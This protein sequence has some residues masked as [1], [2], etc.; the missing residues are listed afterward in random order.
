[1]RDRTAARLGLTGRVADEQSGWVGFVPGGPNDHLSPEERE[2]AEA[3][4]HARIEG[5]GRTLG[6]VVV[7]V[8]ENEAVPQVQGATDPAVAAELVR[9]AREVLASWR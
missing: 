9:R 8:Y 3:E 6:R 1:M 5:R 4:Y 2:R 7:D